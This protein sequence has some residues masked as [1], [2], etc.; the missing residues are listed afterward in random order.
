MCQSR[1][2]ERSKNLS[3]LNAGGGQKKQG[4]MFEQP[5]VRRAEGQKRG[6]TDGIYGRFHHR[7]DCRRDRRHIYDVPLYCGRKGEG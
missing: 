4:E 1:G 5:G 7:C 6:D 2:T 3:A